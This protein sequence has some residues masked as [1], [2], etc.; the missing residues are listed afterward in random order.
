VSGPHFSGLIGASHGNAYV[1][2]AEGLR[3]TP[4]LERLSEEGKHAPLDAEIDAAIA[5]GQAG[6]RFETGAIKDFTKPVTAIVHVNRS[7]PR[8]SVAAMIAPSPDWFAGVA[9]VDLR[10]GS[11][12][13]AKKELRVEAFDAGG[14]AGTTYEAA[15]ADLDPKQPTRRND[16]PQFTSGGTRAPVGRIT[17]RRM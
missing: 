14:D 15:D 4:G 6:E 3:P 2:F 10:D 12:W 17:F 7:F 8:V 1:L 11:G 16:A 13:V 5:A 9:D